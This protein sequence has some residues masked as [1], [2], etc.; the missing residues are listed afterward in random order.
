MN[1][2]Y[3]IK[4]FR[5]FDEDGETIDLKPITILTGCNSS[6]KSSIVKSL[7]MQCDYF[8]ALKQDILKEKP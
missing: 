2:K 4:N 8:A 1:T 5:I 6:G 3:T 7:T